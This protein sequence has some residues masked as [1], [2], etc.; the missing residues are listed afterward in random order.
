[1]ISCPLRFGG[2]QQTCFSAVLPPHEK[3]LANALAMTS[4]NNVTRKT[5][6]ATV[7]LSGRQPSLLT[8]LRPG[9]SL[10]LHTKLFDRINLGRRGCR[11]D[12]MSVVALAPTAWPSHQGCLS[13]AA[14]RLPAA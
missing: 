7:H 3:P 1:M 2:A 9:G 8:T 14:A 5:P 11:L 6:A 4:A 13:F 10:A 12:K